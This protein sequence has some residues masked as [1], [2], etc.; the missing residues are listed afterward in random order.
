MG[1]CGTLAI[2]DE[3][4]HLGL[5]PDEPDNTAWGHI[6]EL[7]QHCRLRL[8]LTGTPFAPTTW[9]FARL[10]E[11]LAPSNELIEQIV[12]D[13]AVEPRELIAAGDVRLV[14]FRAKT[15]GWSTA[16][17]ACRIAMSR[18]YRRKC[19]AGGPATYADH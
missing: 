6:S 1:P 7:T 12:P 17:K 19:A 18:R 5:D 10:A 4:H 3:A 11:C 8:G 14:E 16:A 15:A 13:L 9:P 2:A